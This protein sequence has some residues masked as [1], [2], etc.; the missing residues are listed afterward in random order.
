M[1]PLTGIWPLA[2]LAPYHNN[3]FF[4]QQGPRRKI[5]P[6]RIA[7][8]ALD[9]RFASV[10]P[11]NSQRSQKYKGAVP[12]RAR[13]MPILSTMPV[14]ALVPAVAAL[15]TPPQS[16]PATGWTGDAAD[17][18]RSPAAS[19]ERLLSG[20]AVAGRSLMQGSTAGGGFAMSRAE[21]RLTAMRQ[22]Q[23]PPPDVR[24]AAGSLSDGSAGLGLMTLLPE[25]QTGGRTASR[26]AGCG[27]SRAQRTSAFDAALSGTR[28]AETAAS[29]RGSPLQATAGSRREQ[30]V[31]SQAGTRLS[32]HAETCTPDIRAAA[33]PCN[34]LLSAPAPELS[35]PS[36]PPAL[37]KPAAD[38][39]ASGDQPTV[40]ALMAKAP[41]IANGAHESDG[42][43]GFSRALSK[44]SARLAQLHASLIARSAAMSVTAEFAI[45]IH[46]LA[47][48]CG[49]SANAGLNAEGGVLATEEQPLMTAWSAAAYACAVLQASGAQMAS[50]I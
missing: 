17:D 7:A 10:Q 26:S 33:D 13:V 27:N 32:P 35:A 4:L 34:G 1:S 50:F 18:V 46:L 48:R 28:G 42:K 12:A 19:L 5:M 14:A 41:A 40:D 47:L 22:P 6:T 37:L 21:P 20:G 3:L 16:V 44:R 24:A 45:L 36:P 11:A 9:Q 23:C 49:S 8:A 38:A 25:G 29:V 30:C 2:R 31:V 15:Q 39:T 43:A